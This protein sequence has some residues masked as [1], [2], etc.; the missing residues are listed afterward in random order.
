MQN[1][2]R[3]QL[4]VLLELIN[5]ASDSGDVGQMLRNEVKE[6][7]GIACTIDSLADIRLGLEVYIKDAALLDRHDSLS[8]GTSM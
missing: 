4:L 7:Q 6:E 3:N 2:S 8:H 1:I 5:A